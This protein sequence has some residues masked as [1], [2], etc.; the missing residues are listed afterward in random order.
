MN[1]YY[2]GVGVATVPDKVEV[3]PATMV[4]PDGTRYAIQEL[5]DA[6]LKDL[7]AGEL[8]RALAHTQRMDL[9]LAPPNLLPAAR[10]RVRE[11]PEILVCTHGAR[12][13]R[14]SDKGTPLVDALRAFVQQHK[15]DIPVRE[16]AH[17]GGH[18]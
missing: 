13:C 16:I 17:V 5:S 12:D 6:A 7:D 11:R 3:Y 14:C 10:G 18:K 8:G 4:Y 15:L 2:D 9:S 1:A